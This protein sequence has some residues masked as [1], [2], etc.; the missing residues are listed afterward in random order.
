[1]RDR[2]RRILASGEWRGL[3]Y[4]LLLAAHWQVLASWDR[5]G[6]RDWQVTFLPMFEAI[7]RTILE[8]GQFPW[9]NP[10]VAGGVPLFGDAQAPVLSLETLFAL[11]LG[12]VL[13]SK[14]ALLAYA[15]AG[16]EGSRRLCRHVFGD[17]PMVRIGCVLPALMPAL[18][19]H[20]HEGHFP[21]GIF[22]LFP[23]ALYFALRWREGRAQALG[24]A[25][26]MVY[27]LL[28]YSQYVTLMTASVAAVV[29]A[30]VLVRPPRPRWRDLRLACLVVALVAGGSLARVALSADYVWSFP[31]T[32]ASVGAEAVAVAPHVALASLVFP[33]QRYGAPTLLPT[34]K[35][36]HLW[37]FGYGWWEVGAYVGIFALAFACRAA[38]RFPWLAAGAA[39]LFLLAWNNRDPWFPSYW[40]ERIPPW[41]AL[42]VP[43]R[44]RLFGCYLL[45]VAAVGGLMLYARRGSASRARL[46][47]WVIAFDLVLTCNLGWYGA[48]RFSAPPVLQAP[49]PPRS[50]SDPMPEA[51]AT[52]RRNEVALKAQVGP[53]GYDALQSAR[54]AWSDPDYRGEIRGERRV[55]VAHWSPNR[56]AVLG[57]P[58]DVI[59]FNTNPGSWWIVNGER[60]FQGRRPVEPLQMFTARV[61]E[62]AM[63]EIRVLPPN[64]GALLALQAL[65][66]IAAAVLWHGLRP[67]AAPP[68]LA[69][70]RKAAA[71]HC[72]G[73]PG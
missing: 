41:S 22:Y 63:V 25:A 58:G 33:G 52:V 60:R 54:L 68:P 48:F 24:L 16:Y 57:E 20:L 66:L 13:G 30:A 11:P 73:S 1:M 49:D 45:L 9:W 4:L 18:V 7:R 5:P 46:F 65:S 32:R 21:M 2:L 28:S 70:T 51:W 6:G 19:F 43:L 53:I 31:R 29:A 71:L 64:L 55:T 42:M 37:Y 40:I 59:T 3:H 8:Y 67:A 44:W 27:M 56:V 38:R 26:V 23:A 12:P 72:P 14:F 10:W 15:A 35:T 39:L 61:P 69:A 50:S 17:H 62:T 34:S 47:F 36:V